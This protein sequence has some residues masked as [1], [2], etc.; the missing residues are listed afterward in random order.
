L[1]PVDYFR[2]IRRRWRVVVGLF[3]VGLA[4]AFVTTP[5]SP[6]PGRVTTTQVHSYVATATLVQLQTFAGTTFT[7]GTPASSVVPLSTAAFL[8]T[9]GQVPR[10]AAQQLHYAG[11][12]VVLATEIQG[13]VNP[14]V[15]T[16][17]VTAAGSDPTATANLANAF[18]DQLVSY[19]NTL[20]TSERQQAIAAATA[21]IN[22]IQTQLRQIDAQLPAGA[23]QPNDPRVE[24]LQA[25]HAALV[26]QATAAYQQQNQ[27]L[28]AGPASGGFTSFQRATA[29]PVSQGGGAT[30]SRLNISNR[31]ERTILGGLLGLL[32]GIGLAFLLERVDTRLWTK[33]AAEES[34]GF[35]VVAQIPEVPGKKREPVLLLRPSSP[36]AEAYRTL[37]TSLLLME[38]PP[39]ADIS[40]NGVRHPR[41]S[42][43]NGGAYQASSSLPRLQV[44]VVSPVGPTEDSGMVVANLAVALGESGYSVIVLDCDFLAGAAASYLGVSDGPGLTDLVEALQTAP[45]RATV[46][47]TLESSAAVRSI[48]IPNS[49]IAERLAEVVSPGPARGVQVVPRGTGSRRPAGFTAVI[50]EVVAAAKEMADIVLVDTSPLLVASDA[51]ELVPLADTVL[52]VSRCGRARADAAERA[53]ELLERLRAPVLGV[54]VTDTSA[55]RHR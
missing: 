18:A 46:P 28:T 29:I 4:V 27:L 41:R 52:V 55:G 6:K 7:A 31:K 39:S 26:S 24:S 33:K 32:V 53:T 15:G 47:P 50:P 36:A 30:S 42:S 48:S 20:A 14:L 23:A 21:T 3:V 13:K 1:E 19:L 54:A 38:P 44:L 43:V 34:F 49:S 5:H 17:E 16:L 35:P 2:V 11:N 37:R 51:G 25:E 9:V 45:V 8:L 12:P 10:L 40:G 22:S